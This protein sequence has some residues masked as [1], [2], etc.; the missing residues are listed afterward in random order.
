VAKLA[1]AAGLKSAGDFPVV[2]SS[3]TSRTIFIPTVKLFLLAAA[4]L[5]LLAPISHAQAI[6]QEI[7][8]KW[9]VRRILQ[10]DSISCWGKSESKAILG[11]ELEYSHDLF[12][13]K[14]VVTRNPIAE[15]RTITAN[16]FHDE[17]SG[18]GSRSSQVTFG[19]VGIKKSETLQVT[20]Q[21]P[22]ARITGG[23]IEIPGDTVW[24]K[25]KS[26]IVF[27]ACNVYFEARKRDS[28]SQ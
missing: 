3:P 19:Q 27:S 25:D 22:P 12:R 18:Q 26:T 1:Y 21:H 5:F 13:W 11:T 23:T 28:A 9:V 17:N 14:D 24:L 16:Q 8:G 10:T 6:P 7:W 2:G 20:I 15:T 4:A